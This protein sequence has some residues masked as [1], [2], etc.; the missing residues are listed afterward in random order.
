MVEG[1]ELDEFD[2]TEIDGPFLYCLCS[3]PEIKDKLQSFL[4][5]RLAGKINNIAITE[6][7]ELIT[8]AY[9]SQKNLSAKQLCDYAILSGYREDYCT[10]LG[11]DILLAE[12]VF[13]FSSKCRVLIRHCD[14]L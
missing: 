5:K 13:F 6:C 10:S 14:I 9:F 1:P 2:S 11:E 4:D 8:S 12:P 3:R 7:D